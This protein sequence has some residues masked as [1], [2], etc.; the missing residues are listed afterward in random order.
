MKSII[1]LSF[2][3]L[4]SFSSFSIFECCKVCSALRDGEDVDADDKV[5]K[6]IFCGVL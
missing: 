4:L 1:I 5:T 3:S 2:L 6:V